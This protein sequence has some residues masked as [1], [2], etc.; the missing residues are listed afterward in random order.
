M[1][2]AFINEDLIR[3]EI[4]QR[5]I[6]KGLSEQKLAKLCGFKSP[7]TIHY[8]ETKGKDLKIKDMN[9]I[10]QILENENLLTIKDVVDVHNK[11]RTM[12]AV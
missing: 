10:F 12:Y 11:F 7:T 2:W 5:R 6:K 4:R 8:I 9:K 3:Y 1:G